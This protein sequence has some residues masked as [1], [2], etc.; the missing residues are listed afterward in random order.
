MVEVVVVVA[1]V[2]EMA[3]VVGGVGE[4]DWISGPGSVVGRG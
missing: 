4:G 2:E 3:V 1:V